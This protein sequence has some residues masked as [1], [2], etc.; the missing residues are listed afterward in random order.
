MK[1][2]FKIILCGIILLCWLDVNNIKA[3]ILSD[4][5]SFKVIEKCISDIYNFRF[6]DANNKCANL[7]SEHP[8]QPAVRLL[9]GMII[10][11]EFYPVLPKSAYEKIYLDDM[12]NA[13]RLSEKNENKEHETEN[14]LVN[15]CS[16]GMLLQYYADIDNTSEILSLA[17]STYQ[18]IRRAFRY[19]ADYSDFYFFTGLYNYYREAYPEAYPFYKTFAFFSPMA[20]RI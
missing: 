6:S 3:Q 19:T 4:S 1:A 5:S 10:Y 11:W 9:H 15:L 2:Q 14:L 12:Q 13:V 18:H 17:K 8:G 20:I 7:N 16:R